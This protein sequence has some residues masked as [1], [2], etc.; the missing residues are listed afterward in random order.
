MMMSAEYIRER[1]AIFCACAQI[2]LESGLN[3][4]GRIAGCSTEHWRA[5]IVIV[6]VWVVV[7]LYRAGNASR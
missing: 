4:L 1:E 6:A 2:Y 3:M 5:V 7:I